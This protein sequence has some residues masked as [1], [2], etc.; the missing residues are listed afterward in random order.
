MPPHLAPVLP[1]PHLAGVV[2]D[3]GVAAAQEDL[4][5]VLH[6]GGRG[7]GS[8]PVGGC[9]GRLAGRRGQHAGAGEDASS[10]AM[11]LPPCHRSLPRPALEHPPHLIHGTLGVG[12]IR[13]I[14]DHHHVV[15]VL[16]GAA[17]RWGQGFWCSAGPAT[18][19]VQRRPNKLQCSACPMH[20][21][22]G[23]RTRPASSK[24]A[25]TRRG[26]SW[27]EPCRPPRWTWR[28]PW[29]GTSGEGGRGGE[30]GWL[31][32]NGPHAPAHV[33]YPASPATVPLGGSWT[34]TMHM[35]AIR[36]PSSHRSQ[37][38]APLSRLAHPPAAPTG[39]CRRCCPGGCRTR[40]RWA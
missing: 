21:D 2:H 6:R 15:R 33:A 20:A 17:G 27:T 25:L 28:S 39:S 26:W 3:D 12:H 30:R 40:W 24:A 11:A 1:L 18:G 16:A 4:R 5:G 8:V 19:G 38:Q 29:T 9:M 23:H 22:W 35:A 36:S 37:P 14:L 13:H 31:V 34:T 32:V 10:L 7:K